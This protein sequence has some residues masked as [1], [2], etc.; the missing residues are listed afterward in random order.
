MLVGMNLDEAILRLITEREIGDQAVLQQLLEAEGQ[1]PSQSTLSR[2]LK[3]LGV[4]KVGGRYQRAAPAPAV[5]PERPR[6]TILEAP[7]NLLVIR[8]A[9][10]F[11]PVLALAL[12]KER[13]LPGLAGTVAGDDTIF[14]AVTDPALLRDVRGA[15]ERLLSLGA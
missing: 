12:D 5:V 1:A 9:P 4:L 15:V 10:G 14:V 2:R 6:V 11:A 3:K 7:P 8:T 13:E